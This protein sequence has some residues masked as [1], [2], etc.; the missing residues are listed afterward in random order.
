MSEADE[1]KVTSYLSNRKGHNDDSGVKS[2]KKSPYQLAL[3]FLTQAVQV[4]AT[5]TP[6]L[7]VN[8]VPKL[9]L[10]AAPLV[11][12]T[13]VL[14]LTLCAGGFA[15]E[16]IADWQKGKHQAKT[17]SDDTAVTSRLLSKR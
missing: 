15:V 16:T 7:L 10:A 14:G 11:L 17:I 13:D 2:P 8:A 4:S 6:I 9:A 3:A 1:G 5:L 12:F